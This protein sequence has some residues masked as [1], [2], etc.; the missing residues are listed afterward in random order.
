[1]GKMDQVQEEITFICRFRR[2][3]W[4]AARNLLGRRW[5]GGRLENFSKKSKNVDFSSK[6]AKIFENGGRDGSRKS[7]RSFEEC[8]GREV[9]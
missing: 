2:L 3:S 9:F 7:V 8:F 6:G 1:M 5:L 4:T